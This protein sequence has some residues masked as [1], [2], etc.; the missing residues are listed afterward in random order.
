MFERNTA[1]K[2]ANH[3][4]HHR[5]SG[6]P[7]LQLAVE[8]VLKLMDEPEEG[9]ERDRVVRNLISNNHVNN[10]PCYSKAHLSICSFSVLISS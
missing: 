2:I 5:R 1:T 8:L 4:Q 9:G 3:L 10:L 7:V 6:R